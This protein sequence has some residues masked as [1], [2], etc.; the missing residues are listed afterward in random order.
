MDGEKYRQSMSNMWRENNYACIYMPFV[1]EIGFWEKF[2]LLKYFIAGWVWNILNKNYSN[3]VRIDK[4]LW[5]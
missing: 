2:C 1:K 5:I 3:K 4:D